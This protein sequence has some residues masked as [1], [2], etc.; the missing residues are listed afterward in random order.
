MQTL[1]CLVKRNLKI[2]FKD[3][4]TF[5]YSL[6]TPVILL[7]LYGTF[8]G[9][10][11]KQS[12]LSSMPSE[13]TC[14]DSLID[15]LV[16]SQLVSSLI[17]VISVTICFTSILIMISDKA[18]N[19]I[20]DFNITPVNK[21]VLSLSYFVSS[22]ITSLIM[23]FSC[24]ILCFIY[25]VFNGWFLYFKDVLN[26]ILDVILLTLFGTSFASVLASFLKTNGQANA[27]G[28]I[29]SSG[30]GFVGGAY[31]PVYTFSN[32]VKNII[33]CFPGLYGTSLIRNH[34]MHGAFDKLIDKGLPL[35]RVEGIKDAIDCNL[36][37]EGTKVETFA[38]YLIIIGV[39]LLFLTLFILLTNL[40]FKKTKKKMSY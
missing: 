11:Y 8:L 13:F 28:T 29:I 12:F 25:I 15:A 36:Y 35:E 27:L 37:F 3:K 4:G 18:N 5:F 6:I 33:M 31:M 14:D 26:I 16:I 30:Y 22:F 1:F 2:F 34:V 39:T 24:M 9:D 7:V 32:V 10:V 23:S 19:I 20:N 40:K 38:M 21:K 17:S